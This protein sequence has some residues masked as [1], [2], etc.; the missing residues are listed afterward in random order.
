[1]RATCSF[2]VTS[3]RVPLDHQIVIEL[4]Y[5]EE[6]SIADIAEVIGV[7]KG[8]V[9]SR[10]SR[11]KDNLRRA[12]RDLEAGDIADGLEA[13]TGQLGIELGSRAERSSKRP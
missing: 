3:P 4:F 7:A 8:T 9:S 13:H 12:L 5:W 2:V 6:P 1:M 10:L 11:A